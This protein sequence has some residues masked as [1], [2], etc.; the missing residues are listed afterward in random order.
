MSGTPTTTPPL[1]II[2]PRITVCHT[3]TAFE[4]M[5]QVLGEGKC[6][7]LVGCK[8]NLRIRRPPQ[9]RNNN[10]ERVFVCSMEGVASFVVSSLGGGIHLANS[11]HAGGGGGGLALFA[12]MP[13]INS[14]A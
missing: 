4:K 10:V 5:A 3:L 7:H 8:T 6:Y 13:W 12:G 9:K 11:V 1:I 2:Q 14:L